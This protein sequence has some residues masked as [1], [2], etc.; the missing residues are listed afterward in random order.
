MRY[1]SVIAILLA[2]A[3]I[4]QAQVPSA[5]PQNRGYLIGPGDEVTGKVLGEPQFDF[6]ATI[7]EDGKIEVP[8]FDKPISAKC[9]SERELRAEITELLGKYLRNPQLSFRV[10]ERKSRPP[11][12]IYGEVRSP[13]P[14]VLM[15][16]ATLIELLGVSGGVTE[17]AG[18][19]VQIFR[20]Q[21]PI[22]VDADDDA[23]WASQSGDRTD[24]PY[25]LYSL[26]SIRSGKEEANP[27]IYPGDV[28]VVQKAAPVYVTGEVVSPQ[29]IYLKEGGLSL[30][31]A[32]AKIGGVRREAKTR[33]IKIYRL[34]AG[35]KDRE[36]ITANYDLIKKGQQ[37]D[38]LLEPY[39]IIEVDKARENIGETILK[40]VTGMGR[41]AISTV[42]TGGASR[43]LY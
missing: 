20:T 11:V 28:I 5:V 13:Q 36:I 9:K 7:D 17:E 3:A 1:L 40:I 32:I 25:R 18:G 6:V 26:S 30:T 38:I 14:V 29:G 37:K 22:C 41:S 10:T 34:K 8:F 24:V 21:P 2:F 33:D 12:T 42:A 43:I 27:V 35:S 39:D 19:M 31:E 23:V 15:R 4:S 16:R